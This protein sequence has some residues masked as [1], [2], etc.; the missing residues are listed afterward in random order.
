MLTKP[1][2]CFILHCTILHPFLTWCVSFQSPW[3]PWSP[4][5]GWWWIWVRRLPSGVPPGV[6]PSQGYTGYTMQS[7]SPT[8][9]GKSVCST[10]IDISITGIFTLK[11]RVK[12]DYKIDPPSPPISRYVQK[13]RDTLLITDVAREDRG[14]YQCV[15][16]SRPGYTVQTASLLL[17]GASS[18]MLSYKFEPR[19]MQPGP[20]LSLKCV[21]AGNPPPQFKWELDGF[22]L[23]ENERWVF[24]GLN[25]WRYVIRCSPDSKLL[26]MKFT[27]DWNFVFCFLVIIVI[28]WPSLIKDPLNLPFQTNNYWSGNSTGY[29]KIF[30]AVSFF[31]HFQDNYFCSSIS[32]RFCCCYFF[33]CA[34]SILI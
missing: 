2:H 10:S 6:S 5:G 4:P 12:W 15:V 16:T 14:M 27:P 20:P 29:H 21:A 9:P 28:P 7:Q 33:N 24:L 13:S 31:I 18:P 1:L 19:T 8:T 34:L 3:W 11:T 23:P 17:L 30:V 26:H 22:P 32:W 25:E